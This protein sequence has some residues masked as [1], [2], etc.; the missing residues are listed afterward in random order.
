MSS[1]IIEASLANGD[2]RE[3]VSNLYIS[4]SSKK[5]VTPEGGAITHTLMTQ[6]QLNN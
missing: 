6:H 1:K 5:W 3:I 2:G 4:T